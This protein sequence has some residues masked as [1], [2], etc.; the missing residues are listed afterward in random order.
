[1]RLLRALSTTVL[2]L[3]LAAAALAA[4]V[5]LTTEPRGLV[6]QPD[7][8][9]QVRAMRCAVNAAQAITPTTIGMPALDPEALRITSWNIHKEADA[10]WER[11]LARFASQSDVLLLQEA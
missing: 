5:T 9:V 10:G 7:G 8:L 1:M 6:L 4:C 11:D 2:P 3:A